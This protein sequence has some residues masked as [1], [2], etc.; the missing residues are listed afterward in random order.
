MPFKPEPWIQTHS[1]IAFDLVNPTVD[2]VRIEDI[3]HALA[4]I[5][6]FTGHTSRPYSVAEHSLLVSDWLAATFPNSNLAFQGLMHDA[7]EA[8]VGDVSS[9]VKRCVPE[10]AALEARVWKVVTEKFDL[11]FELDPRVKEADLRACAS[12]AK[13]FLGPPPR[14]WLLPYD[15]LDCYFPVLNSITQMEQGFLDRFQLVR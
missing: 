8:Y 5:N 10:F 9:P 14:D 3:A 4:R 7:A 15:A 11:P 13:Y 2:M 1:G 6:R 12:E